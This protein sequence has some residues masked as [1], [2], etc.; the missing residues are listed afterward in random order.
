MTSHCACALCFRNAHSFYNTVA[1]QIFNVFSRTNHR[2]IQGFLWGCTFFLQKPD[3]LFS[4]RPLYTQ[5]KTAEL[6][7]SNKHLLQNLTSC[8]TWGVQLQLAPTNYAP[9]FF[10]CTHE[11]PG[12]AY[13]TICSQLSL[14]YEINYG[15]Q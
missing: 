6:T 14:L 7:T 1:I 9:N 2:R 12:Y 13:K 3:D 4:R 8:S 5:A 10:S 11:P 15:N